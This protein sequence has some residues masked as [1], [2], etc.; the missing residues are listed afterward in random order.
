MPLHELMQQKGNMEMGISAREHL[1]VFVFCFSAK[2][3][4]QE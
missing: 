1:E 3:Q 4:V 2:H